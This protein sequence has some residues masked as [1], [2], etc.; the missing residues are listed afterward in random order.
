MS[1]T[2]IQHPKS[3]AQASS[4]LK[5][6]TPSHIPR[7]VAK[8]L[9]SG[10]FSGVHSTFNNTN[11]NTSTPTASNPTNKAS[12]SK[13]TSGTTPSGTAKDNN[14]PRL[15]T[16]PENSLFDESTPRVSASDILEETDRA[17]IRQGKQPLS[18][19]HLSRNQQ[20]TGSRPVDPNADDDELGPE[21]SVSQHTPS[22]GNWS[23]RVEGWSEPKRNTKRPLPSIASRESQRIE[24][25]VHDYHMEL[26][27]GMRN[28]RT[29]PCGHPFFIAM[30]LFLSKTIVSISLWDN[31][32]TP[33]TCY[34]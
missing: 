3:N 2:I 13:I 32:N 20:Q 26:R 14:G 5:T 11:V 23:Y 30:N 15:T 29:P 18:R 34:E 28:L 9:S 7:P 12:K 16:S 24:S 10:Q 27:P 22:S 31:T 8:P 33:T 17:A 4:S 1:H 6:T 19:L 21:D 25:R